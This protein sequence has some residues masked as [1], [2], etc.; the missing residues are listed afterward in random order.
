MGYM[1]NKIEDFGR[2]AGKI[3]ETLNSHGAL[4]QTNLMKKTK[5][6]DDE[7]Y[8]AIG[9]LARENKIYRDG[10]TYKLGETNLTNKIGE[11][12]GKIWNILFKYGDIDETYIPKLTDIPKKD[13]YIALG[14]LACEGKVKAKNINPK[15]TQLHFGLK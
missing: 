2:N 14:W 7:F 15:K 5:L 9:W 1:I 3:W 10:T 6:K 8:A 12:A 13:T 11:H 4:T